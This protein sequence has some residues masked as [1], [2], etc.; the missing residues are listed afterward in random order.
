M[1]K[2]EPRTVGRA[3]GS[4]QFFPVKDAESADDHGHR[5]DHAGEEGVA[6]GAHRVTTRRGTGWEPEE[7]D[8]V[9]ELCTWKFIVAAAVMV[10]R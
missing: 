10:Q 6:V 8:T 1:A 7:I 4:G 2:A 5:D 9:M 3:A